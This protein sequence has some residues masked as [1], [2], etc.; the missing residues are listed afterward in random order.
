M[1]YKNFGPYRIYD[2]GRI[3]SEI[4]NIFMKPDICK[5][6]YHQVTLGGKLGRHKVHRLVAYFFCNPPSNYTE[7]DV[8]HIDGDKSNNTKENLEWCTCS[9]N[10][11]HAR[12]NGL[13]DISRSNSERWLDPEFRE[14]ARHNISEG[15]KESG[16]CKGK[17]NP[18]FRYKIM[19][20]DGNEYLIDELALLI[21]KSYSAT[22]DRV[23]K[24]LQGHKIKEFQKYG[25]EIADIKSDVHRLS[26]PA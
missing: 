1:P 17:K 3:Y 24:Y 12:D 18:R 23:Q 7:L 11:K 26:K 20:K 5:N 6:G 14:K 2:D 25:I 13:N 4:R 21:E 9:Y 16:C 8:N 19:D 15:R 22:Y 10:N